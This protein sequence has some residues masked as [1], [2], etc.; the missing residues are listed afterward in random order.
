MSYRALL[1]A[2]LHLS[3][4]LPYAKR[5]REGSLLTDRLEEIIE[6]VIRVCRQAESK[7]IRDVWF[8]GDL[9][10]RKVMDGVLLDQLSK[11]LTWISRDLGMMIFIVP[12]NH[13]TQDRRCTYS[14]VDGL[15]RL[16]RGAITILDRDEHEGVWAFRYQPNAQLAEDLKIIKDDSSVVLHQTV[17][18]ATIGAWR[19]SL[20]FDPKFLERLFVVAGHFHF[21][22]PLPPPARGFYLG[23]AIQHDFDDAEDD[24]AGSIVEFNPGQ[25]PQIVERL[26]LGCS[27]FTNLTFPAE[28][29]EQ[30]LS[31]PMKTRYM[32]ITVA[33]TKA[34]LEGLGKLQ[35]AAEARAKE[36]G[37]MLI[38]RSKLFIAPKPRLAP[39]PSPRKTFSWEQTVSGY[40]AQV[41]ASELEGLDLDRISTLALEA[42]EDR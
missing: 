35:R 14:I 41:Q 6:G 26:S 25:A 23:A 27:R 15:W 33:G 20:G 22:Q 34:S 31:V 19:S 24:R 29:A 16:D 9:V 12:G 42:L 2:D 7:G 39:E 37:V 17:K 30:I 4:S 36:A 1:L 5:F 18:G 40:L 38:W 8:P 13:E 10:D 32:K 28:E 21:A 3:N 11:L